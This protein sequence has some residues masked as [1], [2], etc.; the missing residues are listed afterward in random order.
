MQSLLNRT[1][2]MRDYSI[3]TDSNYIKVNNNDMTRKLYQ[4]IRDKNISTF[5]KFRQMRHAAVLNTNLKFSKFS[6][7]KE[8]ICYGSFRM[9]PDNF[10]VNDPTCY[11]HKSQIARYCDQSGQ[12]LSVYTTVNFPHNIVQPEDPA[13]CKQLWPDGLSRQ[14]TDFLA[15]MCEASLS[16]NIPDQMILDLP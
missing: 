9:D 1:I 5:F 4:F 16:S 2:T 11:I 7:T 8:L 3:A 15:N 12:K 10:R 13:T 14:L 6:L